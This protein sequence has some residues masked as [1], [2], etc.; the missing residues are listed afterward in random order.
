MHGKGFG[1]S[2]AVLSVFAGSSPA[3]KKSARSARRG[4]AFD[5]DDDDSKHKKAKKVEL[6]L[7]PEDED[8]V[9]KTREREEKLCA[10]WPEKSVETFRT[11]VEVMLDTKTRTDYSTF[12]A[13][14]AKLPGEH[15]ASW[16]LQTCASSC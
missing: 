13:E 4:A 7:D 12:K 9:R 3:S 1:R 11:M 15:A 6:D 10:D 16:G 14:L 2:G 8:E 5:S